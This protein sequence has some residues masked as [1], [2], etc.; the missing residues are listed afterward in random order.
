MSGLAVTAR[1]KINLTLRVLGRRPDGFHALDSL[2]AFADIGDT[3]VM[4]PGKP[5]GVSTFGPFASAIIGENLV[6]RAIALT[7]EAEP[8]LDIDHIGIEKLLPVAAG[9]GG[10]SADAAAALRLIRSINRHYADAVDWMAVA[11][12][13]GSDVPVCLL[14]RA[15]RM[16]GRGDVLTPLTGLAPLPAVLVNP[17]AAVPADKTAQVVRLLA[18]PMLTETAQ[19][20]DKVPAA[21]HASVAGWL[22]HLRELGNDLEAP[23]TK[24]VPAIAA[25]LAAL[26]EHPATALARLSGA[27][28]TCFALTATPHDAAALAEHLSE[29]HPAWWVRAT[30]LR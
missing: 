7:L 16:T 12:R 21:E 14:D 17:R 15:C 23:A 2:V 27:G 24:V 4:A 6:A 11:A 22:A 29:R 13:L 25:V 20:S 26:R 5:R 1:A 3:V 8:R 10:G 28:P 30:V 9:I 18:A 19:P